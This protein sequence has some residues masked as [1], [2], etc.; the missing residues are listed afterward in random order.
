MPTQNSQ[1]T[2]IPSVEQISLQIEACCV[3]REWDA[4]ELAERSGVSR[5][6]LYHLRSGKIQRPHMST[7]KSIAEAFGLSLQ[8]FLRSDDQR[9]D[10]KFAVSS[11]TAFDRLTNSQVDGVV[12]E[13]PAL[14]SGWS[15]F[16][17]EE[18]YSTF[19]V[20]GELSEEGVIECAGRINQNREIGHQL[21]IVLETHLR[22]VAVSMIKSLYGMVTPQSNLEADQD[23]Q[24]LVQTH[25]S[26]RALDEN[27]LHS[28]LM[29][30]LSDRPE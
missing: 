10:R 13:H 4:S 26:Q 9:Y 24:N 15:D 25:L 20:G 27:N 22:D 17:W 5:T 14:F 23:L 3:E 19:G 1:H 18:L 7:L 8:E 12:Q 21:A 11:S 28:P 6:T 29:G 2:Q 16:E 30:E